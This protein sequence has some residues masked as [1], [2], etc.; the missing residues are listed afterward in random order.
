MSRNNRERPGAFYVLLTAES[1][2]T[3]FIKVVRIEIQ[4]RSSRAVD[5]LNFLLSYL[6]CI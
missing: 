1:L 4:I 6:I 3:V 2:G 5:C